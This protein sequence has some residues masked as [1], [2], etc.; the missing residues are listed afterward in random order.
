MTLTASKTGS[1]NT[2][3][4]TNYITVNW[5]SPTITGITP[6]SAVTGSTV[7]ITNLAGTGFGTPAT[8]R[9]ARTGYS[10]ISAT[11]V[12]VVSTTQITCT[13]NLAGAAA[14]AWDV[15]VTNPDAQTATLSGGFTVFNPTIT[16]ITPNTAVNTSSVSITNLA[17]TGFLTGA[18]VKLNRTGSSDITATGVTVVSPTQI[19]CTLP[20]TGAKAA[21]WNVAVINPGGVSAVLPNAFTIT[22]ARQNIFSDGFETLRPSANGWTETGTVDWGAYTP[23]T[24]TRDVRLRG[25][26]TAESIARTISTAGY[27]DIIVSFNWAAQ[28]LEAGEY[29]RAEYSTDGGTSWVTPPLSQINGVVGAAVPSFTAYTSPTLPAAAANN[30]NFR[31]RIIISASATNDYAFIDDVLVTGIPT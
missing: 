9:L 12:V 28:S 30:A 24:G 31:I 8:V 13:F 17:G 6:N 16:S 10:N 2:T 3:T 7:S 14:G 27:S 25:G 18:T 5:A 21:V 22:A 26:G 11:S 19:T 4:K 23:R 1:S 29:V 15:V 20:I